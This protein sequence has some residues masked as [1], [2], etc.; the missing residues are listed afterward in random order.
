[1]HDHGFESGALRDLAD[2]VGRVEG[3]AIEAPYAGVE[4][5]LLGG[6]GFDDR[7]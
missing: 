3:G 2:E 6:D 7:G 1:V 5:E 4:R